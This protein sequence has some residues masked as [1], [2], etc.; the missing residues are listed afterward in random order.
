MMMTLYSEVWWIILDNTS[1][2]QASADAAA[3]ATHHTINIILSIRCRTLKSGLE[4]QYSL[5][6]V[7]RSVSEMRGSN[8]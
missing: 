2:L 8:V 6:L 4:V 7:V 5:F 3:A 1:A